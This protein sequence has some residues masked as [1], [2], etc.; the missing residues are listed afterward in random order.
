MSHL[1]NYKI[2][3]LIVAL[4]LSL[5]ITNPALAA[6]ADVTKVENFIKSIIKLITGF[7]SLIAAG[8]FVFGGF[9]YATSTG[10]PEKLERAKHTLLYSGIGLAIMLGGFVISN[11][12]TDLALNAFG[13]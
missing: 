4:G 9:V 8:F 3:A 5:I 10:H 7:G 1:K 12:V 6:S 13:Q 2:M 11:I